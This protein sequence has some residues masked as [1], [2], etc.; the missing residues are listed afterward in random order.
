[1]LRLVTYYTPSHEA[2]CRRFV[3]DRAGEFDEC[4][5][6]KFGQTCPTGEF[7][8]AGWNDCMLDKL[9]ALID[10]PT[11]GMPTLYVDADVVLFPRMASYAKGFTSKLAGD[12]VAF[13]DDVIQWCA[14]VMMFHCTTQ[15]REFWQTVMHM[16]KVWNLPDQEVI[17]HMRVQCAERHGVLPIR[18]VVIPGHSVCNWATVNAPNVVPPWDGEPFE[19]PASCMAWHANWTIGITNKLRMLERVVLGETCQSA[20]E[21]A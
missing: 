2:M 17:H 11:D 10:L 18:P 1:M 14:G 21:P 8:S 13:S 19:V 9:R 15:V 16:A 12:Q 3:L 20:P 4:R 5:Y 7:H 6:I